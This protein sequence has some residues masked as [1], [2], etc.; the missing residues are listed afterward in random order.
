MK[1]NFS[2]EEKYKRF[3]SPNGHIK[4]ERLYTKSYRHDNVAHFP[5]SHSFWEMFLITDGTILHQW[6]Y[7]S[8]L[9]QCGDV[10]LIKPGEKHHLQTITGSY[11][12]LYIIPTIFQSV[13]DLIHPHLFSFFSSIGDCWV[14][15]N[16]EQFVYFK[17]LLNQLY[18][19]QEA[20]DFIQI[21]AVYIPLV[22]AFIGLFAQKFFLGQSEENLQFYEFLSKI[23][24][25]EYVCG[26]LNNIVATSNYSH[27]HLCKLF[28]ERMGKTLK[29]YHTEMKMLY[30][31]ELLRDK[32]LSILDISNILGYSSLS[33][34]IQLFKEFTAKTPKQYR[35]D[36]I[37]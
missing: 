16:E 34:F 3:L 25:K 24:T 28:K 19:L 14:H 4:Q 33:N 11:T 10:A 21:N 6:N 26:P 5:H 27:G 2:T 31:I 23:N 8:Q 17:Q 20:N 32:T 37:V 22:S 7:H 15:L 29:T 13:C 9:L 18:D 30:A 35:K 1:A 36:L 12:D